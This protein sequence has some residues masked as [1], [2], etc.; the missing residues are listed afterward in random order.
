MKPQLFSDNVRNA[1]LSCVTLAKT[2]KHAKWSVQHLLLSLS[3][4]SILVKKLIPNLDVLVKSYLDA[5]LLGD[6]P[7]PDEQVLKLFDD[8]EAIMRSYKD[9]KILVEHVIIAAAKILNLDVESIKKTIDSV[10]VVKK[11][12]VEKT[13]FK[14]L[15]EYAT[16]LTKLASEG[17]LSTIVGRDKEIRLVTEI[18]SRRGKNNPILVGFPGVGKTSIIEGIANRIVTNKVPNSLKGKRIMQLN[19]AAIT[20]GTS[21]R[22]QLEE[23]ITNI[24]DELR[25]SSGNVLLFI[26]EIHTLVN[27]SSNISSLLKPALARGEI[28]CLG[29][30]T[31]DEYRQIE[32]DKAL[33]RRFQSVNV[34]EPT[35]EEAIEILRG[36]RKRYETHHGIRIS[37]EALVASVVLSKRYITTHSLPE[38]AIS[39]MD[40]AMSAAKTA[41]EAGPEYLDHLQREIDSL[42]ADR[43][44]QESSGK[45]VTVDTLLA[46]KQE[47]LASEKLRWQEQRDLVTT[48]NTLVTKAESLVASKNLDGSTNLTELE[49]NRALL[50][51]LHK[52]KC[53]LEEE[54]K[55]QGVAEQIF[56]ITGIPANK[57]MGSEIDRLLRM[58]E[59]VGSRVIGQQKPVAAI[60]EAIRRS[61]A[62]LQDPNR[63][64]GSFIFLGPT[65]VGK[66]EL[67]KALAEFMFDDE[68]SMIRLDMSEYMEKHSIARLIGSPPGYV[69]SEDGGQ[70]TEAVRRKPYSVVLFDEIEKAHPD[71]FNLLLQV[72]DDGRLTDSRGN[73]VNFR[74]TVIILTSN[75]GSKVIME[76]EDLESEET[77]KEIEELLLQKFR[78]EFLNRADARI[79]FHKLEL[80]HIEKI[81][82]LQI[83][84]LDKLLSAQNLRLSISEDAMRFICEKGYDPAFGARPLRRA[85]QDLLITPLS[86]LLL[87]GQLTSTVNVVMEDGLKI[88]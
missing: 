46:E 15:Q 19:L 76:S 9:N 82:K 45:P 54:V 84:K 50:A 7:I 69:G 8:A 17:K 13:T 25:A 24:V 60:A 34:E 87:R 75:I 67:A 10:K 1:V 65:G 79:C 86:N 44:A 39:L 38:K 88:K 73:V 20:A 16:D 70:L 64:I 22:G 57:M 6:N 28:T 42:M 47:L 2:K 83:K 62:G 3:E 27:G 77:Q 56:R 21:L 26:D 31:P 61:R 74:N 32:K 58:E 48:I 51:E 12:T 35:T 80:E 33:E 14:H 36:I 81:A 85:I 63:P 52:T 4:K 68:S 40:Q 5:A 23:R 72:L 41:L 29:A 59:E 37:D 11:A 71:V 66:T 18:L 49:R 78:P 30:T 43:V 53:I 55:P